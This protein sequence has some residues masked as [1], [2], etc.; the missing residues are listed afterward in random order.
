MAHPVLAPQL[1]LKLQAGWRLFLFAFLDS[2][3]YHLFQDIFIFLIHTDT[4]L[5]QDVH[6]CLQYLTIPWVECCLYWGG[7]KKQKNF[8]ILKTD[9]WTVCFPLNLRQNILSCL[10]PN[11]VSCNTLFHAILL[12]VVAT[13][14][15]DKVYVLYFSAHFLAVCRNKS[16]CLPLPD[17]GAFQQP[18][19]KREEEWRN[20]PPGASRGRFRPLGGE[21]QGQEVGV[22][23]SQ[24]GAD[25]VQGASSEICLNPASWKSSESDAP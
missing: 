5:G 1:L 2:I 19:Q 14:M 24:E 13:T 6:L 25:L 11:M 17:P 4:R 20:I 10:I 3:M 8:W 23:V 12:I 18:E 16:R 21:R 7:K 15:F 22:G 9:V